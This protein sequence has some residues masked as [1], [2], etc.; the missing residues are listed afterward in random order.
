MFYFHVENGN[1]DLDH[2]GVDIA[3]VQQIRAEAIA[4]IADILRDADFSILLDDNHLRLWV[5]DQP[6]AKKKN[7]I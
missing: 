6:D 5:T 7:F 4:A 2:D 3:D 1:T